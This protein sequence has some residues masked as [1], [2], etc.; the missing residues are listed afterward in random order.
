MCIRDSTPTACACACSCACA[1][2]WGRK[3]G[4][5]AAPPVAWLR[6]ESPEALAGA[7]AQQSRANRATTRVAGWDHADDGSVDAPYGRIDGCAGSRIGQDACRC[8]LNTLG[9]LNMAS[10]ATGAE[11]GE[12]ARHAMHSLTGE[13]AAFDGHSRAR[14]RRRADRAA[15]RRA[16]SSRTRPR[17]QRTG[18]R[19]RSLS[20]SW[21]RR[22]RPRR[23]TPTPR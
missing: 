4:G 19:R 2:A 22:G 5:A 10:A 18:R 17:S 12:R 7:Q 8:Y 6:D 13:C 23:R 14:R 20:G 21:R 1:W 3:P 15:R 16:E 11:A 9:T